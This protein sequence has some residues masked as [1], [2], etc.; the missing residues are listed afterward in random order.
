MWSGG[1]KINVDFSS[2]WDMGAGRYFNTKRE[3]DNWIAEKGTRRI[4]D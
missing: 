4:R 1:F 2:G 3:R